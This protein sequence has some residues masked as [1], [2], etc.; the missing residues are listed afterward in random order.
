MKTFNIPDD[1]LLDEAVASSPDSTRSSP[2]PHDEMG[3]G[4]QQG[5][6]SNRM[7]QPDQPHSSSDEDNPNAS[8][9]HKR[10]RTAYN[11]A[12]SDV[13]HRHIGILTPQGGVA[14]PQAQASLRQYAPSL[15]SSKKLGD[16]SAQELHRFAT[17][18]PSYPDSPLY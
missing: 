6:N 5:H 18:I 7:E 4:E 17:V 14:G 11:Q 8:N 10:P 16:N 15:A 2:D 3:S 13:N 1:P 9:A 12:G